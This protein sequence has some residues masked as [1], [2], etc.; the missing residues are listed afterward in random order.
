MLI[1][2]PALIAV[3]QAQQTP[4]WET[5]QRA[6][7]YDTT[8][9]LN[10]K[11]T[12][13][14]SRLKLSFTNLRGETVTA[15]YQKPDG[16]GLFPCV[17][18]LHGLG[19]SKEQLFSLMAPDLVKQG[20]AVIALDAALHGERK[21]EGKSPQAAFLQVVPD[22]VKDWR[23]AL[24]WLG[25]RPEINKNRIGL[26][27]YSMGAFQGS[28]LMGVE[29]RFQAATL[30][31]GGDPFVKFPGASL[32]SPSNF[33]G[34]ATPRP[35]YFAN[36]TKDTTVTPAASKVLI[37]AAKAPKIVNWIE[38]GHILPTDEVK[39]GLSWLA[40]RLK[41][42]TAADKYAAPEAA[43]LSFA[44]VED[45]EA[46]VEKVSFTNAAKEAVSGLYVRP[47]DGTGPFP[48]VL[49]L[50]GKGHSK[51]K[52]LNTMKREFASRGIAAIALDAAGHGDRKPLT[53]TETIFTTTIKDYRQLLPNLLERPELSPEKVGLIGFSMGAMMGTILTA[54]DERIRVALPCV[55]GE[56]ESLPESCRP[57]LFAPSLTDRPIAFVNGHNDPTVPE[58]A[59]K[60]LH[61]A[62][63][64]SAN[65]TIFWYDE[66]DHTI[67]KPTL[68]LG[69]DWLLEKLK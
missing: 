66:A 58:A 36:G 7:A 40:L 13:A 2:L 39:K 6:F 12:L 8:K 15:L 9:P 46:R 51:E 23:Q 64:A 20:F 47:K 57:A 4:T 21:V 61:A 10:A 55:G 56:L 27:G 48:L 25:T 49:V 42:P 43:A 3:A 63:G 38:S 16:T 54:I 28:I 18:L 5:L 22:T 30:C 52:M 67:P 14:Q 37:S 69:T 68:R 65:P 50:H 26:L 31:V 17:A 44:P 35:V 53:D 62:L 59:V 24:D 29:P 45:T 19:G 60:K 1:Y 33:I 41:L 32:A 11:E 34:H